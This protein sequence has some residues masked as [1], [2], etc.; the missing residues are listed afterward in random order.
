[1]LR[2]PLSAVEDEECVPVVNRN[3]LLGKDDGD[4]EA[5][6][7]KLLKQSVPMLPTRGSEALEEDTGE[8]A[9][10]AALLP[11]KQNTPMI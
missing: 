8:N 3:L 11:T 4:E 10:T 1:M 2:T 6:M 9:A 7:P 5:I